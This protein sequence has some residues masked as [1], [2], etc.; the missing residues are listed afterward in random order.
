MTCSAGDTDVRARQGK[1]RLIVIEIC[2]L[3][4]RSGMAGDTA[5]RDTR[6]RVIRI[7][8]RVVILYVA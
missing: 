2:R 8:G 1:R 4:G 7:C 5:R 6:L 3:P